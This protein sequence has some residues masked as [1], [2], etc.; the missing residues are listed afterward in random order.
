MHSCHAAFCQNEISL[1]VQKKKKKKKKKEK[2]KEKRKKLQAEVRKNCQTGDHDITEISTFVS[3]RQFTKCSLCSLSLHLMT[4]S[5]PLPAPS[6]L[7]LLRSLHQIC[8]VIDHLAPNPV[9]KS[10]PPKPSVVGDSREISL[11]RTMLCARKENS[12][13]SKLPPEAC[14]EMFAV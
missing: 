10:P 13:A 5:P 2:K 3:A 1:S 12:S 4:T 9:T 7:S 6:R 14:R 11:P 8:V